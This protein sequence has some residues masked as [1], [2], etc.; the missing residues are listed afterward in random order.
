[1]LN[2]SVKYYR[3]NPAIL[4]RRLVQLLSLGIILLAAYQFTGF[5]S[6]LRSGG[7][8]T[9]R[10]GVVEGFLPVAAVVALRNFFATGIFD[11]V[12][13]AGLI[14][15]MLALITAFIFRR[16]LCSWLCPLGLLSETLWGAGGRAKW[17]IARLPRYIDYPLLWLKYAVFIVVIKYF[18]FMSAKDAAS[19]MRMPYYAISDIKMFDMFAGL[20]WLGYS[21]IGAL[22]LLTFFIRSFWCRYLCPYGAVLGFV[23]LFSPLF[24]KRDK[25]LCTG[26]KK[27]SKSCPGIVDVAK[28]RFVVISTECTG[29]T[30]CV[31]ICP[32]KGALTFRFAGLI[33]IKP[34]L[35]GILFVALFFGGVYWAKGNGM[36][37]SS[38]KFEQFRRL[39][40][41]M[42]R[43]HR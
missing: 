7:G 3:D 43:P 4:L 27:C 35:F 38:L 6:A 9:Y 21:I 20:S 40:Q 18:F 11:T 13:P 42:N 36:W 19:F 8:E 1:M 25:N 22:I 16:G 23:G 33:K 2:R 14:I 30:T 15:L 12:H 37:E 32:E 10:P 5:V 26:C 24:I 17:R 31:S 39:D 41:V 28:S 34:L 29:C